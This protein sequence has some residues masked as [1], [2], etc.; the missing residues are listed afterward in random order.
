MRAKRRG[1]TLVELMIVVTIIGILLAFILKAYTGTIRVAEKSATVSLIAKLE[2]ALTDRIDA[3]TSLHADPT[4]SH[5]NMAAIWLTAAN[6]IDS[7]Q[8]AQVIAQYDYMRAELPDV[9]IV[10]NDVNYPLNFAASPFSPSG[11][12]PTGTF[13]DYLLPLGAG[14]IPIGTVPSTGI[15][16][17][18][19]AAAAALYKQ[20]GYGP[21]GLDGAD[22]DND[23]MIDERDEGESGL[24]ADQKALITEHLA[25]H[26]HK[27]ARAEVLYAILVEGTGPLGSVFSRDDFNNQE[28]KDTDGD[29]LMEFVDAY[30]EPIQFF[31]WPI[32]YKSDTQKGFPDLATITL[33]LS[34]AISAPIG[35][36][37]TI[38]ESRE[39]DPLDPN[40][41]LQS[42]GWWGTA[43]VVYPWGSPR[44]TFATYFHTL[45]DPLAATSGTSGLSAN[46][47]YNTY[48][49]RSSNVA[50]GFTT[51]RA[52]YSRFLVVSGGPDK[53]PGVAR[54]SM[55]NDIVDYRAIDERTSWP[56]PSPVGSYAGTRD[57]T[58]APVVATPLT[59]VQ[60]ENQGG[61]I[62]PNR[63]ANGCPV[64]NAGRNDT[65][66]LLEEFGNDDITTHNLHAAGGPLPSTGR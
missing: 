51:R 38:Y 57:T 44:N 25:L 7:N 24:N 21:K 3:L 50:A 39:Q 33:D 56:V 8:R 14:T 52:Y 27:T 60:I 32:M 62:D 16:G 61:R 43:N 11:G 22:N 41:T 34:P 45:I 4:T 35:P 65:N 19:Y 13:S 48:W 6:V 64:L 42:P 28:V 36:Y 66:T 26:K 40:Q 2:A 17:A 54:L 20:L 31:R 55:P 58:G 23:T 30:G 10:E 37:G 59:L 49:D 1:F 18:S 29:G 46:P 9:F 53:Q 15:K 5:A 12:A 63:N 47:L